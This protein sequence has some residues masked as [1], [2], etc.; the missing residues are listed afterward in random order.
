MNWENQCGF[1]DQSDPV[2]GNS[3]C[4]L[5]PLAGLCV[6]TNHTM[7]LNDGQDGRKV[8]DVE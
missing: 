1:I 6:M 7:R 4:V 2:S 8:A 3:Q 5:S